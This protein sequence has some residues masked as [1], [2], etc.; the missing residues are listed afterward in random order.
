[1]R[2]E[3]DLT[4]E[5]GIPVCRASEREV[6]GA[7]IEDAGIFSAAMEVGLAENCFFYDD[8]RKVFEAILALTTASQPVD[9]IT[10]AE[11]LGNKDSD[12]ALVGDLISGCVLARDHI[13]Y[14]IDLLKRTAYLRNFLEFSNWLQTAAC[15]HGA[16]PESI[17]REAR[18][19]LDRMRGNL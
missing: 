3:I 17:D 5:T 7:L 16:D 4:A 18:V 13:L 1:M 14:H 6:L 11:K 12:L 2:T 8:H 10:V 15:A 9:S 19:N